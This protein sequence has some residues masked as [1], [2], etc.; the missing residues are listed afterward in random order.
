MYAKLRGIHQA[1]DL[2]EPLTMSEYAF[3]RNREQFQA[4]Q[5]LSVPLKQAKP[6]NFVREVNRL[7]SSQGDG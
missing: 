3:L 7:V 2:D 5:A 4:W 6:D 1:I